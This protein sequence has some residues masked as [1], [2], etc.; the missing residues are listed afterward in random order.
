MQ[1]DNLDKGIQKRK[2]QTQP[3]ELRECQDLGEFWREVIGSAGR[4]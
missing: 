2:R 4:R 3:R 1:G